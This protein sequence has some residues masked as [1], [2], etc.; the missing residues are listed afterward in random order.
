MLHYLSGGAWDPHDVNAVA[1]TCE[2]SIQFW[3]LRTMKYVFA[4]RQLNFTLALFDV[5]NTFNMHK[6]WHDIELVNICTFVIYC[7]GGKYEKRFQNFNFFTS[8]TGV[9]INYCWLHIFCLC[10]CGSWTPYLLY[11]K[12]S[13]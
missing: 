9:G 10:T 7:I 5:V 12:F 6:F 13:V 11:T 3:D 8:S 4:L 2:W 1:S